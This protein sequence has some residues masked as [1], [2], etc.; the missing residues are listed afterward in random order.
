M[1]FRIQ[2]ASWAF[3]RGNKACWASV[4]AAGMAVLAAAGVQSATSMGPAP[5]CGQDPVP[6]YAEVGDAP[7]AVQWP[8]GELPLYW[9]P[10]ACLSWEDADR[11][12]VIALAGR[13]SEPGGMAAIME[14]LAPVSSLTEVRF[15]A[16][17]KQSPLATEIRPLSRPERAAGRA[18]F[19]PDDMMPGT[20][21]YLWLRRDTGSAPSI[22][23]RRVLL[24]EADR[25][26]VI[27]E[28][29]AEGG[30]AAPEA[31]LGSGWKSWLRIAAEAGEEDTWAYY[32]IARGGAAGD[33]EAIDRAA[34]LFRHIA[35]MPA[36][37]GSGNGLAPGAPGPATTGER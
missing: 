22:L 5:P 29:V 3:P 21:Q 10:P 23:S 18:D 6:P 30:M 19:Q 16:G 27:E 2:G 17:E 24:R 1:L 26:V 28:A 33:G 34:A 15:P 7:V 8:E 32:F 25:I 14:R 12:P 9:V 4:L 11:E 35:G 13:F 36:D 31:K 37:A 20:D